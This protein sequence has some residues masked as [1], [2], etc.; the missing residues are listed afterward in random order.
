MT[1][2]ATRGQPRRPSCV[3]T[4]PSCICA[5]SVSAWSS[6]CWMT[7]RSKVAR[8]LERAAHDLRCY[9]TQRPSSLTATAPASFRSAISVSCSPFWPDGDGA[10]GVEAHACRARAPC[11]T[12]ISVTTRVSLTGRVLGMRRRRRSRRPRRRGGRSRCPPCTPCPARAGGRAGRR[13]RAAARRP[14][15]STT[16]TRSPAR[17]GPSPASR[18]DARDAAALDDHVDLGVEAPTR[19]DGPDARGRRGHRS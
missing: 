11:A 7:G 17:P 6:A 2:S 4:A 18:P 13:G 10:D 16:R 19:I 12:S 8:V 5:P 1:S 14:G 3:E 9:V 15:R